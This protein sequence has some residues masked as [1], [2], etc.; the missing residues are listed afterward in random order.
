[1]AAGPPARIVA[2]WTVRILLLAIFLPVMYISIHGGPPDFD[3]E[4]AEGARAAVWILLALL[5]VACLMA[6]NISPTQ[7][8]ARTQMSPHEPHDA[9]EKDP[10]GVRQSVHRS[11]VPRPLMHVNPMGHQTGPLPGSQIRLAQN[12]AQPVGRRLSLPIATSRS[13]ARTTSAS[14]VPG[15]QVAPT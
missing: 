12:D 11:S 5:L 8:P 2:V 6:P 3:G 9:G 1:M 14:T 4:G 15:I 10:N 13:R 7:P